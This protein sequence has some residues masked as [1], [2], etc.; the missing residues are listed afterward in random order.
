[1]KRQPTE[2]EEILAS[3]SSDKGLKSEIHE[4]L[5]KKNTKRTNNSINKWVNELKQT[6]L[7]RIT[8]G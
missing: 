8:N 5:K 7:K 4:E 6:V 3:Y 2:W 1:V